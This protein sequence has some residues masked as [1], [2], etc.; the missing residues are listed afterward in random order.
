MRRFLVPA[1]CVLVACGSRTLL[2][3]NEPTDASIDQDSGVL[4]ARTDTK[5]DVDTGRDSGMFDAAYISQRTPNGWEDET[6]VAVASDGTACV[7]WQ[8]VEPQ[9]QQPYWMG[10]RF[11]SDG[12][13]TWSAIGSVPP[14]PQ[15]MVPSDPS[16]TVDSKD[17]FWF[18]FIGVHFTGQNVDFTSPF[19]MKAPKGSTTFGAP[20]ALTTDKEFY[21]HPKIIA[22]PNDHLLVTMAEVQF[23]PRGM[24]FRSNDGV[25]WTNSTIIPGGGNTFT[26]LFWP[27]TTGARTYATF[28]DIVGNSVRVA[29]RSSDDE[30]ASWTQKSTI[31]V[32]STSNSILAISDSSCV[33]F[34]SDVWV[35]YPTTAKRV[36]DPQ[37]ELEQVDNVWVIRSTDKGASFQN[38]S[39][40]GADT[41]NDRV[42]LH[43][44]LVREQSG[45]LDLVMYGGIKL[46]DTATRVRFTRAPNLIFFMTTTVFQPLT[47]TVD[48]TA[49]DWLGDYMGATARNGFLDISFGVNS[50]GNTHISYARTK[51]P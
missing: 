13:K 9:N 49:Q 10:Y 28:L 12:G 5:L 15:G 30:G 20:V 17:N 46:G 29:V 24:A 6:Q 37:K 26:N 41:T 3:E 16:V 42:F 44:V 34:G 47:Y 48:R 33:A 18:S 1:A 23:N 27:C 51:L 32:T 7:V 11:T 38:T 35:A 40:G 36:Q 22:L 4:D 19:V 45:A 31:V 21:D 50:S 8:G 39:V 25:N 43:P 14:L 2:L